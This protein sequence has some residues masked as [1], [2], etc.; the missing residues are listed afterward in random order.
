M[1]KPCR[2]SIEIEASGK[3]TEYCHAIYSLKDD[4]RRDWEYIRRKDE[5]STVAIFAYFDTKD[6]FL[7]IKQYRPSLDKWTIEFPAGLVGKEETI[8]AGA[9][10]E[11]FEET[12]YSG[13]IEK[14]TPQLCNTPGLSDETVQLVYVKVFE[15]KREKQCL[16][17]E[18]LIEVI[19][20]DK[21]DVTSFIESSIK[22][23]YIID[24][25]VW[26]FLTSI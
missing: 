22:S 7:L 20:L 4:K 17:E 2:Y 23:G 25:K 13:K 8:E 11:L 9:L 5:I 1:S 12:G 21:K 3:W 26:A 19:E 24:A 15:G 10:R 18:E 14:I 16:E 6:R